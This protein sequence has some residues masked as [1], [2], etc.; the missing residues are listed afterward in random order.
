MDWH[1][2]RRQRPLTNRFYN[3]HIGR[4]FLQHDGKKSYGTRSMETATMGK[5]LVTAR[6]ENL[7]DL[8]NA[9]KGL[10]PSDQVRRVEVTDALVDTGATGLLLPKRMIAALGLEPLRTRHARSLGGPIT[11]PMYRA[12]RLTIQDRDCAIDVGEVGD[13]F[14]VLIGQI[15]LESLDWVVDLR[16]QKLIGN[17]EHGGEHMMDVF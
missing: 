6:I 17:P 11:V 7:E 2:T 13:E 3:V 4:L 12:V 14:P 10:I 8:F 9:K 5:V 15:P 1:E 16:N